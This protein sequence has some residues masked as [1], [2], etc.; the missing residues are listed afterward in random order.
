VLRSH[1]P[2]EVREG[3]VLVDLNGNDLDGE[4]H[5]AVDFELTEQAR[6]EDDPCARIPLLPDEGNPKL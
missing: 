4:V 3:N 2:P 5:Y 6:L 1:I